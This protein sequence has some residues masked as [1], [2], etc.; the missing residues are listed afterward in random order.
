M[1]WLTDSPALPAALWRQKKELQSIAVHTLKA[2]G[3]LQLTE[4]SPSLQ[5][6]RLPTCHWKSQ[7]HSAIKQLLLNSLYCTLVN[8]YAINT[9]QF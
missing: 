9:A 5:S 2:R 1:G 7:T 3:L 6:N 8:I 4:I